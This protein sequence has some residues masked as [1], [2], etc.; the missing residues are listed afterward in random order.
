MCSACALLGVAGLEPLAGQPEMSWTHQTGFASGGECALRPPPFIFTA[1]AR[2]LSVEHRAFDV[3][4]G[5]GRAFT[6]I[7]FT[8]LF[9]RKAAS[10]RRPLARRSRKPTAL[11]PPVPPPNGRP[12]QAGGLPRGAFAFA[13]ARFRSAANTGHT[14]H[15]P[16]YNS[17]KGIPGPTL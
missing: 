9:L 7:P 3:Q 17:L 6:K 8:T 11:A 13:V 12:E 2:A 15:T 10:S 1:D 14:D 5:G 16:D 4:P